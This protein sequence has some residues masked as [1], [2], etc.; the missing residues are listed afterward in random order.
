MTTV[1]DLI[2][3]ALITVKALAVGETPPPSMTTD[4]LNKF[5]EVLDALT[6]QNLAVYSTLQTTFA[7]VAGTVSYT[8]G[9]TGAVVGQRPPFLTT[10]LVTYQGVDYNVEGMTEEEYALLS[11]KSTPGIP[12]RFLYNPDY[13]NGTL[14]LWPVPYAAATM[15]IYQNKVFANAATIYDT[16]D[17]PP[18][19]R[20]MIRLLLAWELSSDYP[21]MTGPEIEKLESDAKGAI[22]L[23]KRNNRKPTLLR[24]E[25]ADM[26]CSGGG[27]SANW[28]NGA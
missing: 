18:G 7:L 10:A 6:I 21:G 26:D 12:S 8:I 24:S 14:F 19:Y 2:T 9:P 27:N 28:R 3:E 20:R 22:G 5:N 11:L 17:M 1:L 16:F 23:V 4:A 15:T 13:P 25:V